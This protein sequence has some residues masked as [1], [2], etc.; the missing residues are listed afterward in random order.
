MGIYE[1]FFNYIRKGHRPVDGSAFLFAAD[2]T[3]AT[4]GFTLTHPAGSDFSYTI[5]N[6]EL[7]TKGL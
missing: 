2:E 4:K 3:D 7:S 1:V 5:V 6:V